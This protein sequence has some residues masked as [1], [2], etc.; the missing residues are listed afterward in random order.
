M[1]VTSLQTH[2]TNM[3]S[4]GIAYEQTL[5]AQAKAAGHKPAAFYFNTR[6]MALTQARYRISTTPMKVGGAS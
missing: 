3:L 1:A 2:L 4:A 5:A 6:A